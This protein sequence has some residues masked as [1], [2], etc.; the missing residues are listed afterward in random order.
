MSENGRRADESQEKLAGEAARGRL[1]M[2]LRL[3][4]KEVARRLACEVDAAP[5][6]VNQRSN[7]PGP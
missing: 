6:E 3:L 5:G 4:A 7:S 2:L 1:L